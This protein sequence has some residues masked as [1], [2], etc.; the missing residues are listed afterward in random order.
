M[1]D[2]E[3]LSKIKIRMGITTSYQD[4]LLSEYIG[5]VKAFMKDAGVS[6]DKLN[7]DASVGCIF[8]GVSDL[9]YYKSGEAK[10]SEFFKHR[11]TQLACRR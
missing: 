11:V 6:D 4:E 1:T 2:A 3:M 5:D 7:S 8:R 10:F 9:W